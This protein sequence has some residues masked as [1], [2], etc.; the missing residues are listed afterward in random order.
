[1]INASVAKER[2][3]KSHENRPADATVELIAKTRLTECSLALNVSLNKSLN[4]NS[5]NTQQVKGNEIKSPH[6]KIPIAPATQPVVD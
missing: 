2:E 4:N 1:M 3:Q 5:S 6:G